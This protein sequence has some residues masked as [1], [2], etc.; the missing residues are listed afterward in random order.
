MRQAQGRQI[1]DLDGFIIK[2]DKIMLVEIKEKSPIIGKDP[3]NLVD[4]RYG[5][6]SRRILWYLYILKKT[7]LSVLYNVR[8][9]DN[10]IDRNFVQWDSIFIDDFLR[11]TSWSSSRGGGGGE[12]TLLAPYLFFHRLEDILTKL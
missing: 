3:V 11:G 12:D 2:N 7:K 1:I 4:W 8:Q 10:R 5:W 9:I 6:D